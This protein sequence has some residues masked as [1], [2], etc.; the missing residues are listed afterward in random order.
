MRRTRHLLGFES[1]KGRDLPT[2]PE[3]F[4]A[5]VDAFRSCA[6]GPL[7]H[8]GSGIGESRGREI[9]AYFGCPTAH[10]NDAER[11]IRAALAIQ[12]A[13]SELNVSGEGANA[14]FAHRN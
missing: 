14:L 4:R 8:Y 10:E 7:A 1:A 6:A 5:V 3:E 12:Q 11:S 9:A 2:D 13:L